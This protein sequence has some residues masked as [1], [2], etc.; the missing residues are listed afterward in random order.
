MILSNDGIE[1]LEDISKEITTDHRA[2]K[3][4]KDNKT[5]KNKVLQ[6]NRSS[7]LVD[8]ITLTDEQLKK[9]EV[10][11]SVAGATRE[12]AFYANI[13][14]QTLLKYLDQNKDYK[15]RLTTLREGITLRARTTLSK[16]LAEDPEL[17]LK[18]LKA[19]KPEEFAQR[20]EV[21]VNVATTQNTA[22]LLNII[23]ADIVEVNRL[24]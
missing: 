18:F 2:I 7:T 12:M 3:K 14:H 4:N 17:A 24:D 13:S 15:D 1:A 20:S 9:I 8:K 10:A 21:N 16:G 5:L 19:T 23:E 11:A 22:N 6:V